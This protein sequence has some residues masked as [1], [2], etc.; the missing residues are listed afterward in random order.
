LSLKQFVASIA[1]QTKSKK[2][3]KKNKRHEIESR[4]N[5]NKQKEK[6]Y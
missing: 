1:L 5:G 4:R 6:T 2:N 3:L